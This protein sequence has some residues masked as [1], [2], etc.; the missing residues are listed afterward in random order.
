MDWP[1]KHKTR[2]LGMNAR[3][4]ERRIQVISR[5]KYKQINIYW[6]IKYIIFFINTLIM[7]LTKNEWMNW[8]IK[9]EEW[10]F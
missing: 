3:I 2:K 6:S 10:I 4:Q 8:R 5:N 9:K 1:I 7:K